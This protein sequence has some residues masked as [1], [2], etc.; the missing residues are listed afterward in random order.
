MHDWR[1]TRVEAA[2]IQRRLAHSVVLQPLSAEGLGSP[3]FAAG[4]D[5]SCAPDGSRAWAV[6]V[7]MDRPPVA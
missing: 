3:R 1:V 7:V 4:A 6:A 5:V 2:A